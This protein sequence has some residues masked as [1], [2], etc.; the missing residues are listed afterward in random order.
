MATYDPQVCHEHLMGIA[1][2][3]LRYDPDKDFGTWRREVDAKLRE[4]VGSMPDPVPLELTVEWEE[5]RDDFRETR[6]H[7]TSEPFAEVPCHL[8]LPKG[9]SGPVPVVICL[10]GHS[11]G[12]HISLGRPKYDGDEETISGGDRDFGI[13]TVREGY[14]A[15]VMEQ[16]CLG[17]RHDGRPEHVHFVD[18]PCHHGSMVALLLGRTMTG[19]RAWDVSRAI[20]AL[21]EFPEVDTSRVGCMGNSGGGTTTYFAAC[22]DPRISVAMPSSYVCTFRDSAGMIDHCMDNYI[23]GFLRWFEMADVACMIAPRPMVVVAGREDPIFPFHGVEE[24]FETIRQ[25]YAAA[26][27]PDACR[28]VVGEGGHRFYADDAWPVFHHISGW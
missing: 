8:L 16:R 10:Q 15:L 25:I 22:L 23:P 7:F 14:A 9:G 5:D 1:P 26:G 13:R 3:I 2:R 28:L 24:M 11:T 19:E 20:D 12:M 27:A 4:I 21:A 18:H 6:F 17:E